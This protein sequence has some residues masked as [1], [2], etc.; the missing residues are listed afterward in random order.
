MSDKNKKQTK[1]LYRKKIISLIKQKKLPVFPNSPYQILAFPLEYNY[2]HQREF[3]VSHCGIQK[4]QC[5]IH[6][7][8]CEIQIPH[9]ETE[10]AS[11]YLKELF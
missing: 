11:V 3:S 4:P 9:C 1:K 6:I 7:S 2:L 8:H 10:N 5:G